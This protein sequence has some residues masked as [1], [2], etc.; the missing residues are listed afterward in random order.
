MI[1]GGWVSAVI[2]I[3]LLMIAVQVGGLVTVVLAVVVGA[4]VYSVT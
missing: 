3:A 4:V 1:L 2:L